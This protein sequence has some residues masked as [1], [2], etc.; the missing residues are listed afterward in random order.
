MNNHEMAISGLLSDDPVY[1]ELKESMVETLSSRLE[2][3]LSDDLLTS[4]FLGDE[5]SWE[6]IRCELTETAIDTLE[7]FTG[8]DRITYSSAD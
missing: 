8:N 3:C 1:Q 5:Y 6:L 4:V 7:D 2:Q